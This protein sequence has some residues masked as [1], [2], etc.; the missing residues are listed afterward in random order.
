MRKAIPAI[1]TTIAALALTAAPAQAELAFD[2]S[3]AAK[4]QGAGQLDNPTGVA[5]N[6]ATGDV[7][8]ADSGNNR[9]VQFDADGD[10]I[11][12]WGKSVDATTNGD[13][14]TAASE[15]TC[16][17]GAGGGEAGQFSSPGSI[18]VDNSDG[19]A[20]GSVYVQDTANNR[21]QRFTATGQFV[22]TWGKN[23]DL[24]TG[25]HVC[26][27]G[28][29]C[30]AGNVSGVPE[31][32]ST[33]PPTPGVPSEPGQFGGWPFGGG[34]AV[35]GEGFVYVGDLKAV[36]NPR[37]QKF[38][39]AASFVGQIAD[40]MRI[41]GDVAVNSAGDLYVIDFEGPPIR[42]AA[43]DFSLTGTE[44]RA[45]QTY[46]GHGSVSNSTWEL[47]AVDPQTEFPLAARNYKRG[48]EE[49]GGGATITEFHPGGQQVDCTDQLSPPLQ[50]FSGGRPAWGGLAISPTHKLYLTDQVAGQVHVFDVPAPEPPVVGTQKVGEITL[51]SAVVKAPVTAN[52]ADT[53]VQVQYGSA[54]C[55]ANPCETSTDAD[56]VGAALY[57]VPAAVHIAGL[58]PD[59]TYFYRLVAT[60]SEGP[61]Y[62]ADRSF[63]TYPEQKFDPS[64]ENNLARQQTGAGFLLDCRA[65]EL[66]SASDQGGYNVTSDLVP[67]ELPFGGYPEA[68]GRALYSVKDGGIPGTGNPTNR[69][70]DPYLAVRDAENQRWET[71]YVG[72]PADAPEGPSVSPP[73]SSTLGGADASLSSFAFAGPEIC[74]PCFAD[75]STG[76]PLRTPEGEL[77]QGMAGSIPVPMPE[78]VPGAVKEQ[79]SADGSHLLFASEQ[80]FEPAGNPEDGNLTIYSRDLIANTTEVASTLPDGTTI[81]AGQ[82]VVAL[83]VSEDGSRVVIGVEVGQD[84]AGNPLHHLYLH[85][86]GS[87]NSLELTPATT[88]GAHYAGMSADGSQLYFTTP[89]PLATAADQDTDTSADLFRFETSTATLR[90]V[91]LGMGGAGDTDACDPAANSFNIEDWNALPGG[92]QDC[93]VVAVGGGGGVAADGTVHF[94]S[95]EKL[96]GQ[97]TEGAP[98][99]FRS[100]PGQAPQLL[101]TLE[102]SASTPLGQ[103]TH[104]HTLSFGSF[105]K[106]EGVAIDAADGSI[107]VLDNAN[108]LSS[109]GAYVQK[110]DKDG[111]AVSSFGTESKEDG[112]SSGSVFLEFGDSSILGFPVG[113]PTQ[114]AVDNYPASP[115]YRDL[116][117][118]DFGNNAVKRFSSTGAYE[119]KIT[120]GEFGGLHPVGVAVNPAN[121]HLYV[122][123]SPLFGIFGGDS[124]IQVYNTAEPAEP[125]APT[126]F[127][128]PGVAYSV[129][130][131]SAGTTYVTNGTET[132]IYDSSGAFVKVL[133]SAPSYGL[134]VDPTDDHIYVD[135][136][137]QVIEYD[138]SGAQVGPAFGAGVLSDSV[139][140]AANAGRLAISDTA[141][142]QVAL[143]GPPE[144]PLDAAYDNPL[145]IDSVAEPDTRH[146][147][148]FQ[149]TPTS[150]YAAF[151]SSLDLTGSGFETADMRQ[152]FRYEASGGQISCASCSATGAEPQGHASLPKAGLGLSDDGRVFFNTAE[153]LVLR[154]ANA[155][156]DAYEWKE[157]KVELISTGQDPF[158][159]GLLTVTADGTDAFFFTRETLV[160]GDGNGTLMKLYDAREGGGFFHIPPPPPCAAAD[161]CHGPGTQAAP[162]AAIGTLGSSPNQAKPTA[163]PKRCPKGKR[164]VRRAG[165]RRCVARKPNKQKQRGTQRGGR[166]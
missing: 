43:G 96:D 91:S 23:V 158:D 4:G 70:P 127:T 87:P 155:K 62:G 9:I 7:Y 57:P 47:I 46:G 11:R 38:D 163:K 25:G 51:S 60:N 66:V 17:A 123:A 77:V 88:I 41:P 52:L 166:R 161:E 154:D 112:A 81:K 126:S 32:F 156:Q 2:F 129:A 12:T 16:Q 109:P 93:S 90:R 24:D 64:C 75:G 116:Y 20:A 101:A 119:A 13:V 103:L 160:E 5:V 30:K 53:T 19:P 107:Y 121:G 144:A 34:L 99:L 27:A 21:I 162:P 104:N 128:V 114:V 92:A 56:D 100:A 89:D 152:V 115:N 84:A 33:A 146:T 82:E 165:K 15:H 76:I 59:T 124:T 78:N 131:D 140:L 137:G 110:F 18:A 136:Q 3:F 39:S 74:N 72:I 149:V 63:H 95:P 142:G 80:Q 69:G 150:A 54:P 86:A 164:A 106:P 55:S 22:L 145:V 37:V 31:D 135:R 29:T 122:A 8:V 159:S 118:P 67:G 157:G 10:F 98:N 139:G 83:D 50:S 125:V 79:L 130:V 1:L 113:L 58:Q 45:E 141:D 94:L 147:A 42:F 132:R 153:P 28:H 85:Q 68:P 143:F 36:P 133:E 14:C 65:Y 97:G 73:F 35:D 48:C 61:A 102:S 151:P 49:L 134:A 26:T 120:I 117:V 108:T 40:D 138:P 44:V 105:G 6:H 71:T 111:K 148:D